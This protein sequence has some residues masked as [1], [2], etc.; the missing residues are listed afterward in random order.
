MVV[1]PERETFTVGRS[2]R[3]DY[4]VD[5]NGVSNM[6]T[7]L[8]YHAK[9]N[10]ITITDRSQNGTGVIPR[11][12]S[13]GDA[14]PV[15]KGVPTPL[16]LG[17]GLL[18]PMKLVGGE[19]ARGENEVVWIEETRRATQRTGSTTADLLARAQPQRPPTWPRAWA[20]LDPDVQSLWVEEGI[21]DAQDLSAF[22]TSEAEVKAHLE[23]KG[24]ARKAW[25]LTVTYWK[26]AARASATSAPSKVVNPSKEIAP[27]QTKRTGPMIKKRGGPPKQLNAP[28][29]WHLQWQAK[30]R[31]QEQNAVRAQGLDPAKEEHL[32]AVWS[33]YLRA[34]RRSSLWRPIKK[35][36]ETDLK[37]LLLR[38][39]RRY[40]DSMPARLAA[41]R[42]WETWVGNQ[43]VNDPGAPF[44]P[45]DLLMGRY[46]TEV[47]SG[48]PTAASQAWAGMKWWE[49]RLGLD[50]ALRSPFT[51]DFR[52]KQPGHTTK[53]ADVLP[54]ELV[55]RLRETALSDD[56][57]GTFASLLLLVA[58]GCVRFRH[59]Q[60][61]A[62][63]E[64]TDELVVCRCAKGKRRQQGIR[65]AFRWATPRCWAPGA[66]TLA[67]AVRIVRDVAAKA[68]SYGDAPFLIPDLS[69]SQG[70][71]IEPGD[72]WLPRPMTY[73][74]FI[75][76]MRAMI[77]ELGGRSGTWTF[78]ALR[79]LMPTGADVLQFSDTVATAIGNWQDTPRGGG[80]KQRSR[81][82]DRMAKR[83]A[84]DRVTT[85]GHYKVRVVAAI[86]HAE[87]DGKCGRASGWQ[88][89]R[90]LYPDKKA[91]Y[92]VARE[93]VV[94][95]EIPPEPLHPGCL[96]H[97]ALG[98][99]RRPRED[100][101]REVPALDKVAWFM[102]SVASRF[103][104]PWVHFAAG[105]NER[106]F[107]RST[108]FRR[109]PAQQG[110]GL[111][112][113]AGTGER[114]CPRC[115]ARMGDKAQSVVAE[116]CMTEEEVREPQR[117]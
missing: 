26:D 6:H 21:E 62:V 17:S 22:Y 75:A 67:R 10:R 114:P 18:I 23:E 76:L 55:T 95:D 90:D 31:R 106:P 39:I 13:P 51:Q 1:I 41:W 92:Q 80:G 94:K 47:E 96:P 115:L 30:Q 61:S 93:F 101:V 28:G 78:N 85:A 37:N 84:G 40:A 65:E 56:T 50:L 33:I 108:K 57:R 97:L 38:P 89:I 12:G 16:R 112:E 117:I 105:A 8:T 25:D 36:E 98:P 44:K 27:V 19:Q 32:E 66:D 2:H 20:A 72:V 4:R 63:V 15:D 73:P 103:Q 111:A 79:R 116:F 104:R 107:C 48:G 29:L 110:Q 60:R 113:A 91:L 70:H 58:G 11:G 68:K 9:E 102:Q 64:V 7:D 109:D 87:R 24:I 83:Y 35:E 3:A 71:S 99:L 42:R 88:R 81:M 45:T 54:L 43:D 49:D 86:W 46:L 82:K 59:V 14:V 74:R 34:G 77:A 5:G 69:T 100:P 53:Q 52:L